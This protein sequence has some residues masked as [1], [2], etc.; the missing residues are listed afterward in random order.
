ME[1]ENNIDR[2]IAMPNKNIT[3]SLLEPQFPSL[4]SHEEELATPQFHKINDEDLHFHFDKDKNEIE[5]NNSGKN[6]NIINNKYIRKNKKKVSSKSKLIKDKIKSFEDFTENF[7]NNTF[8]D[9][10]INNNNLLKSNEI[11]KIFNHKNYHNIEEFNIQLNNIRNTHQ[12]IKRDNTKSNNKSMKILMEK[13]DI[14]E[15][16]KDTSKNKI[17]K[18]KN[19]DKH[20][21]T[22]YKPKN[23]NNSNCHR[24]KSCISG[25]KKPI[26]NNRTMKQNYNNISYINN[27]NKIEDNVVTNNNI[28]NNNKYIKYKNLNDNIKIRERGTK[29]NIINSS[30]NLKSK[31]NI[32]K[33]NLLNNK[34]KLSLPIKNNDSNN[35]KKYDDSFSKNKKKKIK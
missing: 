27:K 17:I 11:K 25:N 29:S 14:K 3:Y 1:N 15:G 10:R 28:R 9:I 21:T 20:E 6:E 22:I 4:L 23:K 2:A 35:K 13:V 34:R 19:M 18:N 26:T 16:K 31:E 5:N 7:K 30:L 33:N 8:N 24:S 12:N 32:S